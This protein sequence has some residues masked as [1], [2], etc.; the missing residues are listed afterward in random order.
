MILDEEADAPSDR[1]SRCVAIAAGTVLRFVVAVMVCVIVVGLLGAC[2]VEPVDSPEVSATPTRTPTRT[3]TPVA[4]ATTPPTATPEPNFKIANTDG[5]GVAVRDACDDGARVSAPGEGIPEETVVELI[6]AGGGDCA[7]WMHVR[8]PDGRESWVRSRYLD[9]LPVALA[10][11]Q[12]QASASARDDLPVV[13]TTGDGSKIYLEDERQAEIIMYD[14]AIASHLEPSDRNIDAWKQISSLF[15]DSRVD[16]Y[17]YYRFLTNAKG[18]HHHL[19]DAWRSEYWVAPTGLDDVGYTVWFLLDNRGDAMDHLAKYVNTADLDELQKAE[20]DLGEADSAMLEV[21]FAILR[22]A[23]EAGLDI[24]VMDYVVHCDED[25][26]LCG[27]RPP[28][29]GTS[30][31]KAD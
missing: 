8:A 20:Q 9:A 10:P 22:A 18:A 17:D 2:T 6:A 11:A 16:R 30:L 29:E 19:A 31:F 5:D 28:E 3:P 1:V 15:G 13:I 12:A 14:L 27:L 21:T 25:A 24:E 26:A 7:E 4:A 23:D